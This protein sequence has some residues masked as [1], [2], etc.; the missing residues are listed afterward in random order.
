MMAA[1]LMTAVATLP[2]KLM[3]KRSFSSCRN[4]LAVNGVEKISPLFPTFQG[5][6]YMRS[7]ALLLC[8]LSAL[9]RIERDGLRQ[10]CRCGGG[11]RVSGGYARSCR[12]EYALG[13]LG[14][15]ARPRLAHRARLQWRRLI[16]WPYRIGLDGSTAVP[17]DDKARDLAS[18]QLARRGKLPQR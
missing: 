7:D 13:R 12:G 14:R 9:E 6:Y 4:L 2:R 16:A 3:A 10:L 15:P 5:R 18:K 17:I 11:R 8:A 1:A